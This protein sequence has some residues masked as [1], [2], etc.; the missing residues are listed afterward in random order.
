MLLLVGVCHDSITIYYSLRQGVLD[1]WDGMRSENLKTYT[2]CLPIF[3]DQF[4]TFF[5][6]F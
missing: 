2:G 6:T 5:M 3:E 1:G 4:K